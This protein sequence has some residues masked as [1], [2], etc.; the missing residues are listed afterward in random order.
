MADFIQVLLSGLSSGCALAIVAMGFAIVLNTLGVW[1]VAHAGT[2]VAGAYLLWAMVVHL[3]LPLW[4]AMILTII[5]CGILGMIM[6]FGLYRPLRHARSP[7]PS[8]LLASVGLTYVIQNVCA[9][10][11]GTYPK[12]VGQ[13]VKVVYDIGG[14]FFNNIDIA[15]ILASAAIFAFLYYF[16]NRTGVGI[17]I[18]AV[19]SNPRLA[20]VWG[21]DLD[22]VALI[23]FVV[24]SLTVAPASV[25]RVMDIGI[26]PF[27]GWDV[28]ILALM[29]YILGGVGSTM[30]AG[31]AGLSI[32]IIAN[33]MSWQM[34][35]LWA[36]L[37]IFAIV[38]IF[39]WVRPRGILGKKIWRYEV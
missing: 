27:A 17:S 35:S 8:Y 6:E 22:K 5:C 2:Y 38:Y 37:V 19:A 20:T 21:A 24:A 13:E 7:M 15:I 18:K 26:V 39:M 31:L 9:L 28:I 11:A 16:L 4:L 10:F 14:V 36:P 29:A 12:T 3:G 23:I 34:P 30:G 25:I 32:G 1:H 33:V